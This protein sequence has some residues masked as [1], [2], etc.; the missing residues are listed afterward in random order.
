MTKNNKSEQEQ[1]LKALGLPEAYIQNNFAIIDREKHREISSRGGKRSGEVRRQNAEKKRQA[2]AMLNAVFFAGY[3]E[4]DLKDFRKW[5][6][7]NRYLQK[8]REA[9]GRQ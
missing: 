6:R 1:R 8:K 3:T 7:H 4:Q 5:Q 9:A 2:R